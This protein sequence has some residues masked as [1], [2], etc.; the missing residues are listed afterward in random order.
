MKILMVNKFLYPNGGSETYVLRL[1]E[2]LQRQGDE[3]QYFGMEDRRNVVGNR[4]QSYT[5]NM[6]FHSGK[7][8]KLLYPFKI[9]YSREARRAIRRV[10]EDFGPDAVHLNN[11]N[12]QITPSIL[13]EIRKYEKRAGKPVRIIFTAHDYQLVCPN[14]LMRHFRTESNCN[15]CLNGRY[16]NCIR[17]KCIHGSTVKS[18][19]GAMEGWLYRVL[20][21]YR[22][23]DVVIC[24]SIFMER[25]M[26]EH[27][28]LR[29]K[30]VFLRNFTAVVESGES[31]KFDKKDYVIY[32]GR[33]AKEKGIETLLDVCRRLPEI[34]F[35]FAG[36]GPYEKRLDDITNVK[37]TG[38]LTAEAIKNVVEKARFSICPSECYENCPFSVM[39]SIQYGTPVIGADIGGIPELI[40]EGITGTVFPSGDR[41]Q[42]KARIQDLWE[43]K[44]RLMDYS[45]N[46]L[47]AGFT[48]V[49]EYARLI[50]QY[51]VQ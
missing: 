10:L 39:E 20:R 35:V 19:L 18:I 41:E 28:D 26:K 45:K 50:K 36:S 34:P 40:R 13:Y 3:V 1:G 9:I 6:D 38:L 22:K 51:Y 12:F 30:T 24:P 4:V 47:E 44:N 46:C 7:I 5:S 11:F 14:H 49:E 25:Q 48:S 42:L 31:G 21:T 23:I 33:Y 2:E 15:R 8:S 27:P 29:C 17:G 16:S 37:N 43:D 32:F